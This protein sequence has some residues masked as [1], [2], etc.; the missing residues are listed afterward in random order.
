M[1]YCVNFVD[2]LHSPHLALSYQTLNTERTEHLRDLCVEAL[3]ARSPQRASSSLVAAHRP[4]KLFIAQNLHWTQSRRRQRRVERGQK[5]DGQRG[6]RNP[7]AVQRPGAERDRG[8][9]V[10]VRLKVNQVITVADPGD[11]V[12]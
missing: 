4:A 7:H 6:D 3:E 5:A 12:A 9:G 1:G 2:I 11:A 8:Q 10:N